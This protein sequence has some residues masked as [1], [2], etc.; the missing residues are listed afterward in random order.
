MIPLCDSLLLR[1][2]YGCGDLTSPSWGRLRLQPSQV[3]AT[4]TICCCW[5]CRVRAKPWP[6]RAPFWRNGP[7]R[8]RHRSRTRRPGSCCV[9]SV[10]SARAYASCA[11]RCA[12]PGRPARRTARPTCWPPWAWRWSTRAGPPKDSPPSIAPSS[13]LLAC[14]LDECCTGAATCCGPFAGTRR[15][16]T[17]SAAL[18]ASCGARAT[19]SGPRERSTAGGSSTW[20]SGPSAARMP[21]SSRPGDCSQKPARNWKR[22]IRSS[23]AVSLPPCREISRARCRSSMRSRPATRR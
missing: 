22:L 8:T 14:C 7:A 18:S 6:R 1:G 5:P 23:T 2:P 17:T 3:R 16:W 21:T 20:P 9:T 15:P 10:T 13:S 19:R 11:A 12:W 4:R